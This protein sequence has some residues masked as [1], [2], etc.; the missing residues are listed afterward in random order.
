MAKSRILVSAPSALLYSTALLLALL[1]L[2]LSV[3]L[4]ATT[5]GGKLKLCTYPVDDIILFN[6]RDRQRRIF[7]GPGTDACYFI[8]LVQMAQSNQTR[9]WDRRFTDLHPLDGQ[10]MDWPL[11]QMF[12]RLVPPGI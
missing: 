5:H 10:S 6:P 7:Y 11:G 12:H 3:D 9:P 2:A 4:A 8:T 1:L